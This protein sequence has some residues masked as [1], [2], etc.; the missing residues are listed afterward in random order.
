MYVGD[1]SV[2]N[3]PLA[4]KMTIL[5]AVLLATTI[6]LALTGLSQLTNLARF[7]SKVNTM[8]DETT[9]ASKTRRE[10]LLAVRAEKNAILAADKARANE[11]ADLAREHLSSAKKFR[12]DLAKLIGANIATAEGKALSDLDWAIEEFEKNQKE[13]LRLAVIKSNTEGKGILNKDLHQHP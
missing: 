7:E 3:F 1:H 10:F 13:V 8:I 2:K 12:D 9:L 11:F 4:A 6:T 5:V